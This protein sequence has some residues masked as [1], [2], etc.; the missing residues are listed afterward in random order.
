M[1]LDLFFLGL[2]CGLLGSVHRWILSV[3]L[4]VM[5][6]EVTLALVAMA[7]FLLLAGFAMNGSITNCRA[8]LHPSRL[9]AVAAPGAGEEPRSVRHGARLLVIGCRL[10]L[11]WSVVLLEVP[12]PPHGSPNCNPR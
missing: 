5:P 10:L 6:D 12:F 2:F 7:T 3:S 1:Q 9:L 11:V 4:T 8:E